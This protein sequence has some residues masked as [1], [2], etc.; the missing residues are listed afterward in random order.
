MW[1]LNRF[2]PG[3]AVNNI[4]V[5]VRLSGRLDVAAL[6]AA[7]GDLAERHE[8]LRTVYPDVD[9]VGY[10]VVLPVGDARSVPD[11]MVRRAGEPEVPALVAAAV[12]EGFD[13]TVAP[14]VRVRLI[15]LSDTEHVLVCV[16]HHIAG[17]GFSMG[18]L[19]RD[20]MSA[21][22]ERTRGGAPGWAPLE[23][24]YA[25]FA[26]WQ[27]EI[28]GAEDDPESLLARQIAFWRAGLAGLPEQLELP[29][30]RARPAMAS[31]RGATLAFE[32]D[33][34]VHA[35]LVRV[36]HEHNATLFM[37]VHAALAVL[38]ARLSGSRDIAVGTPVAGRGEAELDDL[39]GMF[40]NTLVLRT[41]IDPGVGFDRLLRQV[42]SVDVEAFGHADVPFER[43]VELLDPVRSPARHPLF[44]VMLT[45]QNLARAELEL[46]GL[47]VSAVDLAV[48]LAKF[49]LQ[50][51]LS[52]DID[53]HG[54]PRGL[55]AAFTYATDLFDPATVQDFADRFGRILAAVAADASAVVGDIDVLAAGERELV[56]HEWSTPGAV[57]PEVT[58]V[59][60]IAAQAR[61]RPD[62]IAI[63]Y[64]DTALTF[65][66]LHRR[67]NQVARALIALGAG[68]ESVVAVAVPR[69][70]ELPV[71]LLGVL[72]A[73]AAY[74]P[75][76]TAYPVQRLEFMLEDAAPVAILTT[77]AE[78]ESLP[79]GNVPV[80]LLEDTT[81]YDEARVRNRERVTP[82]RPDHL[83]YV[84]YTSGSTGVPKGVG[85]AHRNVVELFANTQLLFE[86]DE[87]DVWTL[88]HSFAF[89]FSVWELWCALANGGTVVVVD[90]LTSRSPEQFRELLIRE[91][92]T[93][94]NQTPSA[95]YQLAEADR[96]AH[97]DEGKFALRYIVFGGEAL[98]LRQLRRWYERH[99]VDAPWLVNMYGITETTVHVSFL[100]LDEQMADNPASVI[101]RA[102]PGLDAYVLDDRVHPAPVGVAGEIY[103]AG[104]QLSR[105][106]LGRAGLTAA[107]FVANPFG[108]PG[109]RMYRSGDIGR[110]VGFG[111]Q[112]TLEYAGRGDQQVQLRGFRIE[113]GEIE[114]ALLRC[115][116]VSQAVVVVR[117]DEHAGDRLVGYVVPD[118]G[119]SL[120]ASVLRTQVSEFLTGYMVPDAVVVLDVLPLTANGKLDRR[121][122]PEP[123]FVSGVVF[124]APGSPVEQAVAEVFAGLLG[125]GEVGLD[126]DF[127][128][129]GGNS[130]LATRVVARINEALDA[131]V[132]VRELFAAPTVAGLAARVVPGAGGGRRPVLERAER[133]GPVPLSLA[134]QRMWVLNQFDPAS[135]AYNIPMA[136]RLSGALDVSALRYAL[137][138]VLERHESLRTRYPAEGPGGLPFQQILTVEQ[139]LPGGLEFAVTDD[140][141][142]RVGELMSSGFDVTEQVPV[143]ALLLETGPEEFLLAV[144]AHHIAADGASMA[145]LARDLVT[146]YLA[147][148]GGNSPRWAPL[149][150][151][152]A[153]Y[154][155]WQRQVI[156]TD[157][158][159][160]SVAARQLAYWRSQLDG[161][162]GQAQLPTDRP[163]PAHASMRGANTGFAVSAEVHQ[164]LT[165]LAREHNCTL[166]MVVH[167]ALAVLLARLSGD[168]DVAIGTP[169]AGRGERVLDDLVGM[170]VNT[171]TLR[172][173]VEA[174]MPFTALVDRARETDLAAFANAD[175]PFERVV[176][177]VAPGRA[178]T[179]N[180]LFGVVLSFQNNE[181][182]TLQLPGLTITALDTG[183][184]AAKFDLQ[185]NVHPHH[186]DDGTP[187][188]LD[189]IFTYATDLF[190][191]TTIHTLGHRLERI[192]T[193]IATNPHTLIGDID[194]LDRAE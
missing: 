96:A 145:P 29:A 58:L 81:G 89:D 48:P 127:F 178:T 73:G 147:R 87:T 154:A 114:A 90:Y 23:V 77:A 24:Q 63:R 113:L 39:V 112:A 140:P 100:S 149:E 160:A 183:T 56:L 155:I 173:R 125:A 107:R 75:I 169:I 13:V 92:V 10:Q 25:D 42:R 177:V 44:Q 97:H 47:S 104:A 59:E 106:Y 69:T 26:L 74:L 152:Y 78:R 189:T 88:F 138:D 1:F 80:L 2:D 121:G 130:L 60:V 91:Q 165:L 61:S 120:D 5:A 184:V 135:A 123:E 6:R 79:V 110:W 136:I 99:P 157:E 66:E 111:G 150:V 98:D 101:G 153:D 194:I 141:V 122:L 28:L 167:A 159:P 133:R 49:D 9:G 62:A 7:V 12:G 57:V 118:A 172:T 83:A 93:V 82:L 105:G 70:E 142:G 17:D 186:R 116:G 86:F 131:D 41:E 35:G 40:V 94:L 119:A 43:L 67:A 109:S 164:A 33:A 45:F 52:E 188:E 14:P 53:R 134:Q 50:L 55:S 115:P 36:A 64:A 15:E 85:V 137:A 76:D 193:T 124:R 158:D 108:A 187:G 4:P 185:V 146:A 32:V 176:E 162:S 102:L 37:V 117:A 20:L 68:P 129:L 27:R 166:F 18:P 38:L 65:G 156:G 190:D 31:H 34:E 19:T 174:G 179:H 171:L 180:P 126:D 139:A 16:V 71:A 168:P 103:V 181:Q 151:Q 51:A 175:I 144:V 182:P 54:Q 128:A 148:I 84:I 21:Y 132:A 143:R 161:L 72:T 11:V 3:S 30:D 95:F 46:P 8:V 163:R 22:V 170:F 191:D 192:L